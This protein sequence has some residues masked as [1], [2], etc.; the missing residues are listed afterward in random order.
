MPYYNKPSTQGRCQTTSNNK[1]GCSFDVVQATKPEKIKPEK[2]FEGY[3]NSNKNRK[4]NN[5]K[6]LKNNK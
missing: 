4:N 2:I 3:K 6:R 5:K 1:K